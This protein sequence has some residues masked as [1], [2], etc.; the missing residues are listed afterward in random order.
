MI[1]LQALIVCAAALASGCAATP[2]AERAPSES[3]SP[4]ESS[5]RTQRLTS[6]GHQVLLASHSQDPGNESQPIAQ[7]VQEAPAANGLLPI[8]RPVGGAEEL[9]PAG[10]LDEDRLVAQVVACNPSIQVMIAAWEAASLRYPQVIALDDPMLDVS[11]GPGSWARNDVESAYMVMAS[12]KLPWPGKRQ[13]RAAETAAEA[14][15]EASRI[16]DTQ[17]R[18]AEMAKRAFYDYFAA[19]RKLTLNS[20]NLRETRA[21]R[22]TAEEKLRA[23]LVAQQDVLQADVELAL[24]E[25]RK[26]ELQR[27]IKVAAA[28]INTLLHREALHPLPPPPETLRVDNEPPALAELRDIALQRRPDLAAL[29]AQIR[30]NQAALELAWKEFYPDFELY[31]KYDAFWQEHPL[32][33]AVGVNVNVPL[34]KSRRCAA[35]REAE[36]RLLQRRAEYNWLVDEFSNQLYANYERLLESRRTLRL[37]HDQIIPAAEMNVESARAG[38]AAGNVDFL[39]LIETQRQLIELREQQVETDSNCHRRLAELQRAAAIPVDGQ[40]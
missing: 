16:E 35:V 1:R 36:S 24:L 22:E 23:N 39:R 12:Q 10:I 33:S 13:L 30:A 32:R 21:F 28:R 34:S 18:L 31:A 25:R 19:S 3:L 17:L 7:A 2:K 27:Q 14:D 37:F 40:E 29:S 26:N 5:S 4:N 6:V 11:V 20:D 38:Y 9:A 8:P 15:A